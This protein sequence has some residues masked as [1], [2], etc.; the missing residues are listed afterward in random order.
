MNEIAEA[1]PKLLTVGKIAQVC[2][3]P[4]HRVLHVIGSRSHIQPV[5]RAG[6]LRLFDR[7]GLA[8]IRHELNAI[9]AKRAARQDGGGR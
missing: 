2:G 8:Q 3:V 5:A 4:P 7:S 6:N 9:D 1:I